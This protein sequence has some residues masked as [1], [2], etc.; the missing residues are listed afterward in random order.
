[1]TPPQPSPRACGERAAG[2][3]AT[4]RAIAVALATLLACGLALAALSPAAAAVPVTAERSSSP[5]LPQVFDV[6]A[7]SRLTIQGHGFGNGI[8]LSQWGAQGAASEHRT[9]SAILRFYYPHTVTTHVGDP[10]IRVLVSGTSG[11]GLDVAPA[12]GLVATDAATGDSVALPVAGASRYRVVSRALGLLVQVLRTGHTGWTTLALTGRH[13]KRDHVGGPVTFSSTAPSLELLYS[14]GGGE[15]YQGR[16]VAARTGP[17]SLDAI[18]ALPL[19]EYVAGVVPHESDPSWLPAALQAQAVAARTYALYEADST[20]AGQPYQICSTTYCQVYMGVA[21][22]SPSGARTP[23]QYASTTAATRATA[24]QVRT[25]AGAPIYAGYGASDGGWTVGDGT[26][27]LVAKADPYDGIEAGSENTWSLPIAATSFAADF[28]LGS[29]SEIRVLSRDGHGDWGG[30]VGSVDIEGA[31]SSGARR[32]VAT[33]GAGVA[34]ALGLMSTWWNVGLVADSALTAR[35]TAPS[36]YTRPGP[37]SEV[38][39]A[40]FR[41]NGTT[42]WILSQLRLGASGP[43]ARAVTNGAPAPVDLTR[44]RAAVALPGD[45]VRVSV[46]V[47]RAALPA[48]SHPLTGRLTTGSGTFGGPVHWPLRVTTAVLAA[49]EVGTPATVRV[50]SDGTTS[51]TLGFRNTGNI[52]WPAHAYVRL[53]LAL[54]H[55]RVDPLRGPGWLLPRRPGP[56]K[57]SGTLPA[58]RPGALATVTFH[59]AGNGHRAG[60]LT[61]AFQPVWDG[62]AWFGPVV[63]LTVDVT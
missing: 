15:A 42:S 14:G 9:G 6:S 47:E 38:L 31:T 45:S 44:P 16:L 1:M 3:P 20:P 18:D 22:V 41:D 21:L 37:A 27:Y 63:V 50:G 62:V 34:G 53:G 52:P 26:P 32:T 33:T 19:Q 55:V 59:L 24:G 51:V 5:A 8:G 4:R 17:G 7:S 46:R 60:S 2:R 56:L 49:S 36:L 61:D 30:R 43:G 57:P 12:A 35:S 11:S 58:T 10:T 54:P 39:T 28:G 48:G 25:Y 40:T 23:L 13:G 29:L